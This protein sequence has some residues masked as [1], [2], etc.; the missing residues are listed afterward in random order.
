M[1]EAYLLNNKQFNFALN[2][3]RRKEIVYNFINKF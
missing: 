2:E 3:T 1:I